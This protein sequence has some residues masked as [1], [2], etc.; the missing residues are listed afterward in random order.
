MMAILFDTETTGLV[1]NR[2]IAD[3]RQPEIIEFYGC[4]ANLENGEVSRE[5]DVLIRPRHLPL[6]DKII[7]IT[8]IT[9]EMV[10]PASSF[11]AVAS[12]IA[13]IL[14]AAPLV[15]AHNASFDREVIDIEMARIGRTVAWP[16]LACTVEQTVHLTGF[17][18]TLST[19]HK[20]LFDEDF[21]GAHRAAVDV[22]ALLRCAVELHRRDML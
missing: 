19:L 18:L 6:P 9:T 21:V 15:I 5:L 13:E 8:G 16:R 12:D 20:E 10:S 2:T 4:L 3:D 14:E 17:R 11:V 1:E 7:K 22:K